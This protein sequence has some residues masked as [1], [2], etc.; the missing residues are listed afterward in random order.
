MLCGSMN[1]HGSMTG[2]S[3]L[4]GLARFVLF[5]RACRK[6]VAELIA[7]ERNLDGVRGGAFGIGPRRHDRASRRTSGTS[8]SALSLCG[9]GRRFGA[10]DG[11]RRKGD[12]K[13]KDGAWLWNRL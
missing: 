6:R 8:L 1:P 2:I 9:G 11:M 13:G 4:D 7:V 3:E 5:R 12:L 10:G